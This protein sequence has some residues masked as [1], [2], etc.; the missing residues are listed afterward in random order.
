[1]SS[2]AGMMSPPSTSPSALVLRTPSTAHL[3]HTPRER[4]ACRSKSPLERDARRSSRRVPSPWEL[5]AAR[6][7]QGLSA[8]LEV[9]DAGLA[10]PR[11]ADAHEHGWILEVRGRLHD[12]LRRA[13]RNPTT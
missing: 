1:V 11:L 12:C 4:F 2:A 13:G 6:L 5:P 8:S 9:L 3:R 7:H 10:S